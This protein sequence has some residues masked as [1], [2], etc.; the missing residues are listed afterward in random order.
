MLIKCPEC[1]QPVSDKAIACPHCG[2]PLATGIPPDPVRVRKRRLPNGFGHITLIKGRNLRKPYRVVL[3]VSK[4]PDMTGKSLQ[5][6]TSYY[7][8][9]D[10]AYEALRIFHQEKATFF[11]SAITVEKLYA[12]WSETYYP[13]V[14]DATKRSF[15][16]AWKQTVALWQIPIEKV[17]VAQIKEMMESIPSAH[18]R[19]RVKIILDRLFDYALEYELTDKN[20][21]RLYRIPPRLLREAEEKRK[22]HVPFEEDE[23][24]KL[25]KASSTSPI[26]SMILIQCYSGWRPGELIA[27]KTDQV[28]LSTMTMTGGNKTKAGKNR[29]VPIHPKIEKLVKKYY[30]KAKLSGCLYLFS[31]DKTNRPMTYDTYHDIFKKEVGKL[32]LNPE[33]RPH[34]P[35]VHFVTKCKE[36]AVDEYAIKY[37]IG[38]SITDITER[39]YTVRTL[40]WLRKELLKLS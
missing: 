1:D 5:Q 38:H 16:S 36:H 19:A 37:L 12:K 26:A 40:E 39:I 22:G 31:D 2:Y 30:R 35:R 17:H 27:I 18:I 24:A 7:A 15:R 6:P 10:E 8:S 3:P 23:I 29:V 14:T 25:W 32:R 33:H 9:Y 11:S 21:A 28:D 20:Y 34:D 4:P 13:L